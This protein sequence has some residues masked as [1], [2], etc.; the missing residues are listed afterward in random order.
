M[1]PLS[2]ISATDCDNDDAV[3][4]NSDENNSSSIEKFKMD[5]SG[6]TLQIILKDGRY[7]GNKSRQ[8]NNVTFKNE[9]IQH[10]NSSEHQPC[11]RKQPNVLYPPQDQS[12]FL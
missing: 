7:V 12:L 11:S 9:L 8:I 2:E 3:D 6:I 1:E 5:R 10:A 4:G